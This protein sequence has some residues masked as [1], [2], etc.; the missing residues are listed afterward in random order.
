MEDV[1][2]K[3]GEIVGQ[4]LAACNFTQGSPITGVKL[5]E[6]PGTFSR[7]KYTLAGIVVGLMSLCWAPVGGILLLICYMPYCIPAGCGNS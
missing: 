3:A 5:I 6:E 4:A 2:Q 7:R 1:A